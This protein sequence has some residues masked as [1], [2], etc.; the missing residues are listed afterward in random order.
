[1]D[2]STTKMYID[3]NGTKRYYNSKGK[4]HRKDGPAVEVINGDKWWYK[5][6]QVHRID[7][8]AIE[9]ED[10]DKFWFILHKRLNEKDFNSWIL[11]LQKCI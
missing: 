10:G 6:G 1:M 4:L 7:G 11:R 8:S 3:K 5:E 2:D 9:W